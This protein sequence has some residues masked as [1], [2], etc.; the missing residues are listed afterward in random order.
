[1]QSKKRALGRGLGALLPAKPPQIAP[2][3]VEPEAPVA[4]QDEP[5]PAPTNR[6]PIDSLTPNP[7]QPRDVFDDTALQELASS[8][9]THGFI[10]PIAVVRRGDS[11]MIVAGERRWRAARIAEL[12]E[13]PVIELELT[14]QEILE[15][16]LIENLQRENLNAIEEARAYKALM[17]TFALSQ[18]EVADRVGKSRPA[19]A[20]ALRLLKLPAEMQ[21]DVSSGT[22]SAGHA[23]ALL[24]L[25][26]ETQRKRLRDA[27]VRDQMSVR[28]AE[29]YAV[30]LTNRPV[31]PRKAKLDPDTQRLRELLID[32]LACRVNVK[33]FDQNKGKIEIFYNSLDELERILGVMDVEV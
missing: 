32:R 2:Q 26:D 24:S 19:I 1:M 10:Q 9:K 21:N 5:A 14:E 33:T 11:F 29:N 4:V 27:I 30:E 17:N 6:L 13:V 31:R 28:E 15:F 3:R 20:N 25:E 18:D 7:Y 16:A 12:T 8:L 23:R 22:I